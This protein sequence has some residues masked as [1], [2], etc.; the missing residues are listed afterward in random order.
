MENV[1]PSATLLIGR[2]EVT[3]PFQLVGAN[4]DSI[5]LA[6]AWALRCS[7]RFLRQFVRLAVERQ[8][9]SETV[10]VRVHR[11]EGGSGITDI[12]IL[13][14]GTYHLIVETPIGARPGGAAISESPEERRAAYRERMEQLLMPLAKRGGDGNLAGG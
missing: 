6:I 9:L 13:S 7:P 14:P 5:S 8:V 12:E 1:K 11:Y 2:Y 4:E 3:N 10:T